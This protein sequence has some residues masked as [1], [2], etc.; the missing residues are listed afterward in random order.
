MAVIKTPAI[1]IAFAGH[2]FGVGFDH[3]T[4]VADADP[5]LR[6]TP[7]NSFIWN[8]AGGTFDAF[9]LVTGT[10]NVNQNTH[11]DWNLNDGDKVSL[12]QMVLAA[13][14]ERWPDEDIYL[15]HLGRGSA[16]MTAVA[17]TNAIN[18]RFIFSV[19]NTTDPGET[20]MLMIGGLG[21]CTQLGPIGPVRITGLTGLTP[22]ING[23]HAAVTVQTSGNQLTIPI[24]TTGTAG[25][26]G[27][28]GPATVN[29]SNGHWDPAG[30]GNDA[31]FVDWDTEMRA[32]YEALW[33]A[34]LAPDP[35][36]LFMCNGINDV[37]FGIEDDFQAAMLRFVTAQ[38]LLMNVRVDVDVPIVWLEPILALG[39][40]AAVATSIA[41]IRSAL[42]A[43]ALEDPRMVTLNQDQTAVELDSPV[44]LQSDNIHPTYRGFMELGKALVR[45]LDRITG[46]TC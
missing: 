36:G 46:T 5:L 12:A 17:S 28:S 41:I 4:A 1:V 6:G 45:S 11:G 29:F 42:R 19:D 39:H 33:A 31:I 24:A 7:A 20:R 40:S 21:A 35:R 15:V 2:S 34:D 18:D 37:T 3:E 27:G 26:V 22:D 25:A 38:R 43:A 13:A 9:S 30:T 23:E 8:H 44:P 10:G 14:R 16:T 32:A